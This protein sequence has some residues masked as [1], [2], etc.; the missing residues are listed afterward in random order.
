[1]NYRIITKVEAGFFVDEFAAET[2]ESFIK[3]M[4][5]AGYEVSGINNNPAQREE[6]QGVPK[7]KDVCGPMWDGDALRYECSATYAEFSA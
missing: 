2:V 1:M 6:L 5:G 7:F 4:T 3:Q